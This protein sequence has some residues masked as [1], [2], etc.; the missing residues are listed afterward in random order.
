VKTT[1][2]R[3]V[4]VQRTL[5]RAS[6][7]LLVLAVVIVGAVLFFARAVFIPVVLALLFALVLSGAVEAAHRRGVPRPLSA[8]LLLLVLVGAIGMAADKLIDP[9]QQ[10]LSN[11]PRVLHTIER[12]VRPTE[13]FI[14]RI[15][16]LTSRAGQIGSPVAQAPRGESDAKQSGSVQP[17]ADKAASSMSESDV[18]TATGAT[19]AS[20]I[21]CIILVLFL[22]SGGPPM[23]ARMAAA[24]AADLHASHALRVIEAMRVELGRYY[25]TIAVINL[26]LGVA[27][28][29]VMLWL[30]V[31]NPFLWGAVAGLLNFIP[32]VGS[33]TTLLVLATVAFVSFDQTGRILSVIGS[34]LALATIEGQIVQPF[35][36][37]R[38]LE[39]NPILVFLAVWFGGWFWG[40]GGIVIAVPALVALKVAASHSEDAAAVVEFLS[41]SG[42]NTLKSIQGRVTKARARI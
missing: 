31:P 2:E 14:H 19:A 27:T 22:L 41:P 9:A 33:A 11:A 37:G 3:G 38:R 5:L 17:L 36:V 8:S 21:T 13:A 29:F 7:A 39:L 18:L 1:D 10:W 12:K 42:I 32:Y 24:L 35:L 4:R 26:G 20:F 23:L 40:L 30:G 15:E 6:R 16:A 34:F 28:G 25:G